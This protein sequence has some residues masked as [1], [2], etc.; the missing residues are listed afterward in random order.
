VEVD[1]SPK[2][3]A[4]YIRVSSVAQIEGESLDTQERN[5]KDY[6]RLF[7]WEYCKTYRDEGV[8]GKKASRPGLDRL[9]KDAKNKAFNTVIVDNLSRF[10]RTTADVLKNVKDL[11]KVDCHFVSIKEKLDGTGPYGQFMLTVF[12]A[13]SELEHYMIKVRMEES[14]DFKVAEGRTISGTVGFGYAISR[15]TKDSVQ[16]VTVEREKE[17]YQKMV[18]LYLDD[19]NLSIQDVALKLD[20]MQFKPRR[21]KRWC[22][23]TMAKIMHSPVYYLGKTVVNKHKTPVEHACE[24]FVTFERWKKIQVKMANSKK[25]VGRPLNAKDDFLLHGLLQCG[26]CGA[27]VVP[28]R[29]SHTQRRYYCCYWKE[30]HRKLLESN[31]RERCTLPIFDANRTEKQILEGIA[32]LLFGTFEGSWIDPTK[33]ENPW[34]SRI[35]ELERTIQELERQKKLE[36]RA[37]KRVDEM[38]YD[39]DFSQKEFKQR[40][41]QIKQKIT[42][43]GIEIEEA[44]VKLQE[45]TKGREEQD[46]L[47]SFSVDKS[48][49]LRE[50]YAVYQNLSLSDKQRLVKGLINDKIILMANKRKIYVLK[51][52]PLIL[53]DVLLQKYQVKDQIRY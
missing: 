37:L 6:T 23:A 27:K 5:I 22:T 51:H 43:L 49:A 19:E 17:V 26:I 40:K 48:A 45:Q 53:N 41:L 34:D 32:N 7:G 52:N 18:S 42:S 36:E 50:V 30:A 13:I 4:G 16:I 25:R 3:A 1:D 38:I 24:K 10:G 29:D 9:L 12:A 47:M 21:G 20:A 28:R 35:K 44:N 39:E 2:V 8:S 46:F 11:Q 15:P 31:H 14:R 33:N